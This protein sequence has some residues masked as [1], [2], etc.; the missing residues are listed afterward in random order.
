MLFFRYIYDEPLLNEIIPLDT[1]NIPLNVY[2]NEDDY[3]ILYFNNNKLLHEINND[4]NQ[5]ISCYKS[6]DLNTLIKE[7]NSFTDNDIILFI[8]VIEQIKE[9]E[10]KDNIIEDISFNDFI[11]FI[12]D[13]KTYNK[14]LKLFENNKKYLF[15]YLRYRSVIISKY[16]MKYYYTN[17]LS[18]YKAF[19]QPLI[20]KNSLFLTSE[21]R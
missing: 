13:K 7:I 2:A 16:F 4:R 15:D 8:D 10:K 20:T 9:K 12:K 6:N 5:L 21:A 11:K 14:L 17:M 19:L 3:Y 18:S 1:E